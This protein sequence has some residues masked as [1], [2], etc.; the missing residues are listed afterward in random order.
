[1]WIQLPV[2]SSPTGMVIALCND[3]GVWEP[4]EK[5]QRPPGPAWQS[6][7]SPS[8]GWATAIVSNTSVL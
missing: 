8:T 2:Q 3:Q 4:L 7:P 5:A 1:M 6:S